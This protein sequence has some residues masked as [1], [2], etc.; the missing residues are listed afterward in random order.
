MQLTDVHGE[1]ETYLQSVQDHRAVQMDAQS[2]DDPWE[3]YAR[4][5]SWQNLWPPEERSPCCRRFSDRNCETVGTT[6]KECIPEGLPP[7]QGTH[8]GLIHEEL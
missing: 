6:L 4:A 3:V 8:T 7:M 5:G 2:G 1:E